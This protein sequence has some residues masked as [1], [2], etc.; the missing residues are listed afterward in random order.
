LQASPQ[1]SPPSDTKLALLFRTV[2]NAGKAGV[3]NTG[4]AGDE[5][6]P[7]HFV[8][9][10]YLPTLQEIEEAAEEV[11]EAQLASVVAASRDKVP[12]TVNQGATRVTPTGETEDGTQSPCKRFRSV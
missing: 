6:A 2:Y 8:F 11:L 3:V 5:F 10:A 9:K 7:V 12:V 4:K 1:P